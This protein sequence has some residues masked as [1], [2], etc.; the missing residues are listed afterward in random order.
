VVIRGQVQGVWYRGWTMKTARTL[1]LQGWVRNCRDG[2]VEAKFSGPEAHVEAML[3]HCHQGPP[4]AR[5]YSVTVY[6]STEFVRPGF[7]QLPNV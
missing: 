4:A 1:G 5:V 2:S 6:V 3:M 7:H